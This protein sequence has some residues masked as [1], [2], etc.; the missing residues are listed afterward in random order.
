MCALFQ[1]NLPQWV[2]IVA[3]PKLNP[4]N[5]FDDVSAMAHPRT[6]LNWLD[7]LNLRHQMHRPWLSSPIFPK[8]WL[9]TEVYDP[10][11]LLPYCNQHPVC[12]QQ[13]QKNRSF[14]RSLVF[15]SFLSA[16]VPYCN[17][18]ECLFLYEIIFKNLFQSTF[19]YL[20]YP[21]YAAAKYTAFLWI[22]FLFVRITNGFSPFRFWTFNAGGGD[23]GAKHSIREIKKIEK[24]REKKWF[25]WKNGNENVSCDHFFSINILWSVLFF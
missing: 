13:S 9:L 22:P 19:V 4:S 20:N 18:S 21:L 15:F 23:A 16:I 7:S 14:S 11:S 6:S 12:C 25:K 1:I 17:E 3:M 10:Y 8:N 2:R 24:R 5:R